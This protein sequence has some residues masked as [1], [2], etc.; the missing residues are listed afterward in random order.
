MRQPWLNK[1]NLIR[2]KKKVDKI[3][4]QNSTD[5]EQ[6]GSTCAT[7]IKKTHLQQDDNRL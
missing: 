4:P 5:K 6:I 2:G 7:E 3:F 1:K